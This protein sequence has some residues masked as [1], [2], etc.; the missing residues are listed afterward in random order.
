MDT[1]ALAAA[2]AST[3]SAELLAA[4]DLAVAA[5]IPTKRARG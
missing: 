4:V 5:G 3:D 1:V 2:A